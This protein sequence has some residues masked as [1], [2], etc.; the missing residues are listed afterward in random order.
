VSY[1]AS[2]AA[3]G[4]QLTKTGITGDVVVAEP[5]NGCTP[6]TSPVAVELR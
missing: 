2:P 1:G 4:V 5:A 3:F 6:I